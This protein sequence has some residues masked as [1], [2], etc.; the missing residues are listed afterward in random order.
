MKQINYL[1]LTAAAVL[2]LS[3]CQREMEL[4]METPS[5]KGFTATVSDITKTALSGSDLA[6]YTVLWQSGDQIT[7]VDKDLHPG[8]YQTAQS[9]SAALFTLSGG[10]EAVDAPYTAYYPAALYGDGTPALPATQQYVAGNIAQ[11]PMFAQS[12]TPELA[13]KNIC[14]ILRI[15]LTTALSG[16]RIRRIHISANQGMSGIL[17]NA[18]TLATDGYVAAVSGTAGV[19]LDC[20]PEGVAIGNAAT[21]FLLAVPQNDYTGLVISAVTVT[22]VRQCWTL[23]NANTVTVQRSKIATITLPFTQTVDFVDLNAKGSANTYIVSHAGGYKFDA[24]VKGNGGLDPLTGTTATAIDKNTIGGVTVLWELGERGRAIGYAADAYDIAYYDGIVYFQTPGTF[25][26]G[27]ACVAIFRD[28][29]GGT[30]GVYDKDVDEILWSWLIWATEAPNKVVYNGAKFMD[31]NLGAVDPGN[32]MRGFLYQWGRKDA[33][34]A[35]TGSYASFTFVPSLN[36]VFSTV[37]G[38]QSV[39]YTIAHPTVQINNGDANSWMSEAEYGTLPWRDDVKT[40]YDPCPVG[41]RVPTAAQQDGHGDMPATGFSNAINEF[42]NPD[43]GYYRSST[44]SAYPKAYAHRQN[45]ERNDWGTNPAMAIRPVAEASNI[46]SYTDLSASGTANCYIVPATGDYKFP[47]TVKGNGAADLAGVS[48]NTLDETI[49]SADVVWTGYGTVSAPAANAMI[50]D[51]GY[52][53]GYL[54]FSTAEEYHEG[55]ALVAVKD[56]AGNILWSWHLWFTAAPVTTSTVS[57]AAGVVMMDRNL[58]ALRTSYNSADTFDFGLLYQWGRKDPFQ[59]V[60]TRN[61]ITATNNVGFAARVQGTQENRA[62]YGGI[63]IETICKTPHNFVNGAYYNS[64]VDYSIYAQGVTSDMW[65]EDKTIFDPCPPGWKVPTTDMFGERFISEIDATELGTG[66]FQVEG[67][68]WF[69]STGYRFNIS[70]TGYISSNL[71]TFESGGGVANCRGD[72]HVRLWC[73]DGVFIKEQFTYEKSASSSQFLA[74]GT[75]PYDALRAR[76]LYHNKLE[77][78]HGNSVRCVRED[79]VPQP[80]ATVQLSQSSA[81]LEDGETVQ[82]TTTLLPADAIHRSVTWESSNPAVATVSEDGL[83]TAITP[84]TCNVTATATGGANASCSIT[85]NALPFAW[86]DMGLPSGTLWANLNMGATTRA[87]TGNLYRWAETSPYD[88]VSDYSYG[89][90]ISP[91][92]YNLEDGLYVLQPSDDAATVYYDNPNNHIPT[93]TQWD[94]LK[95]GTTY[96]KTV[97]SGVSGTLYTSKVNGAQLFLPNGEYWAADLYYAP[98]Y[99][100]YEGKYPLFFKIDNST[101]SLGALLGGSRLRTQASPV[102]AVRGGEPRPVD[103]GGDVLWADKNVGARLIQDQGD[104]YAWGET[105]TKTNFV[106]GT[107]TVTTEYAADETLSSAEDAARQVLGGS[108]RMPTKTEG[109]W[110]INAEGIGWGSPTTLEGVSV[111]KVTSSI[112]GESIYFPL[113]GYLSGT[114]PYED[115]AVYFWTATAGSSGTNYWS[116]QYETNGYAIRK[117]SSAEGWKQKY[118]CYG[119]KVRGIHERGVQ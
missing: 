93:G 9:G 62:I 90:N 13:F 85:V 83:V 21:P 94:E 35:A 118:R 82:L 111:Y 86:V 32:G 75:Y 41:W 17:T 89:T 60:Y 58:G 88:G 110:L 4:Q 52:R 99:Q 47:A 119:L 20:G 51:V 73:S 78:L 31:R 103:M 80:V 42:G 50:T 53:D 12:A 55:N 107:Y 22:G 98:Y 6:G 67:R 16:Q 104:F 116:N 19:T 45:G 106:E 59:N 14:G 105:V 66:G 76:S 100:R 27:D 54:Y 39:A 63:T 112:T 36:T 108:W 109:V 61:Y 29:E 81:T 101:Y 44:V 15:N 102:R 26:T 96:S 114:T 34:S 84:G 57:T 71:Y 77:P 49:A 74:T 23:K 79:S 25:V 46:D 64:N 68:G 38:I 37:T 2:A 72:Y 10:I 92:K 43:S 48:K 40:I 91:T 18:E 3:S 1:I 5:G 33:F 56:S 8:V 87:D 65:A 97:I 69:P 30:A 70:Y 24:T 28:G 11:S 95:K 113:T 117:T 7:V 115:T